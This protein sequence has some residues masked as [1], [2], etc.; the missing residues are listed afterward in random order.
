MSETML[1]QRAGELLIAQG[2]VTEG[3]AEL[4]RALAFHRSVEASFYVEQVERILGDAQS[5][6]A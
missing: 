5:A 1:R 3:T 6:S 2:S 4:G